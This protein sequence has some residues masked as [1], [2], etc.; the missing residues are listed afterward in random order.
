M[1][2]AGVVCAAIFGIG[3]LLGVVVQGLLHSYISEQDYKRRRLATLTR[4]M[5][6]DDPSRWID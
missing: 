3:V 6:P 4:R 1:I 5:W 2:E